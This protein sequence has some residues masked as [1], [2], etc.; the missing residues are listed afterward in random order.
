M[1]MHPKGKLIGLSILIAGLASLITSAQLDPVTARVER[2]I[3]GDTIQVRIEGKSFT[4]R[5]MGVDTPETKHPTQAVQYG[6][7]DKHRGKLPRT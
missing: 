6:A 2:V 1:R 5:L 4:V 7:R 3:N